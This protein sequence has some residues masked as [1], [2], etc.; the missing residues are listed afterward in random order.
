MKQQNKWE[1]LFDEWLE[2]TEFSLIKHT[3]EG[4][5]SIYDGQGANLGDIESDRFD[6]AMQILDRMDIYI[7]DY[8]FEDLEECW[9]AENNRAEFP[10][11]FPSNAEDWLKYRDLMPNN[12]YEMDLCDMIANHFEE[13]NLENCNYEEED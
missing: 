6:S 5:W 10:Y 13:I 2:L 9:D 4:A 12:Q 7:N 1:K 8:I 11:G 3:K